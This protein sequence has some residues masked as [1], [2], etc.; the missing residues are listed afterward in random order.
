MSTFLSKDI[1]FV[2]YPHLMVV[3][4]ALYSPIY[5]ATHIKSLK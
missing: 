1:N 2:N 5:F 3:Y 4:F